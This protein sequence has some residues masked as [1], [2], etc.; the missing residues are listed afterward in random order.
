[1]ADPF[2]G[3]CNWWWRRIAAGSDLFQQHHWDEATLCAR[4][5]GVAVPWYV[6][7]CLHI[8]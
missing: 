7:L 6:F 1:M 8:V 3:K 2:P 4:S 5:S